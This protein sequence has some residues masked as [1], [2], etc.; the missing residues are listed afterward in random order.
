MIQDDIAN[1]LQYEL[2]HYLGL[3]LNI[4]SAKQSFKDEDFGI[5]KAMC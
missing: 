1:E 4:E 2:I 3:G 5:D